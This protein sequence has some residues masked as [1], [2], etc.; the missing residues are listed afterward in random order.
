M[1]ILSHNSLAV[2]VVDLESALFGRSSMAKSF[3]KREEINRYWRTKSPRWNVM[4]ASSSRF[5]TNRRHYKSEKLQETTSVTTSHPLRPQLT[6]NNLFRRA[7][8]LRQQLRIL[9]SVFRLAE[10]RLPFFWNFLV[11]FYFKVVSN[12]TSVFRVHWVRSYPAITRPRLLMS[13]R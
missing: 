12:F 13:N 2:P 7:S 5:D 1:H 9:L 4:R 8:I 3:G 11:V 10:R 6:D